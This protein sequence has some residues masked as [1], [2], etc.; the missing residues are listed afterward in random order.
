[1]NAAAGSGREGAMAYSSARCLTRASSA[2]RRDVDGD[3]DHDHIYPGTGNQRL[4]RKTAA[5]DP[6]DILLQP[7]VRKFDAL[8][9]VPERGD[10]RGQLA[11]K[12]RKWME[13]Y[14]S[15]YSR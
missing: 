14:H 12:K 15:A 1:M 6:P 3:G 2:V 8:I 13:Y 9:I 10:C 11:G 7:S 5:S 4:K